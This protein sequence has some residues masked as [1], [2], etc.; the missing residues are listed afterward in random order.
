M[1]IWRDAF[2][3]KQTGDVIIKHSE[4]QKTASRE[5]EPSNQTG[6]H[7][8][9]STGERTPPLDRGGGKPDQD[10]LTDTDKDM[11]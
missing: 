9:S 6:G 5:A 3:L 4:A 8:W 7:D 2:K 11:K 1:N 10:H